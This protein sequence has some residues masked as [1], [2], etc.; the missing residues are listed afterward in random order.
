MDP[1]AQPPV[2]RACI[3]SEENTATIQSPPETVNSSLV[4]AR[5]SGPNVLI[6]RPLA[7][8]R[9]YRDFR[10][11]WP[12][13]RPDWSPSGCRAWPQTR[14]QETWPIAASFLNSLPE[15]AI[16]REKADAMGHRPFV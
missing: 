13:S 5:K 14:D 9:D 1:R 4:S 3:N 12:R 7:R 6:T 16:E 10:P 2:P 8:H 11:K 15:M